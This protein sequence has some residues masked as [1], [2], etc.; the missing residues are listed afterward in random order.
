M[1]PY[2]R[3]RVL[4][5]FVEFSTAAA[6]ADKAS[7]HVS[8]SSSTLET[9]S[10]SFLLV[11]DASTASLSSSC[12]LLPSETILL[13]GPGASRELA[14]TSGGDTL[15]LASVFRVVESGLRTATTPTLG[16]EDASGRG[17]GP[18]FGVD[19]LRRDKAEA[20]MRSWRRQFTAPVTNVRFEWP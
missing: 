20:V 17:S 15:V 9:S 5:T 4:H 6:V 2:C 19:M 3:R 18:L 14:P 8:G 11:L 1:V 12:F 7:G 10:F 16:C 13:P